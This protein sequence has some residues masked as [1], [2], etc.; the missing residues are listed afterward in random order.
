M[1]ILA[2]FKDIMSAN[3]NDLLDKCED[4]AKMVDQEMRK[5]REALADVKKET[6]AVMA[7][8]MAAKRR[9]DE[10]EED[11]QKF[12]NAAVKAVEA[13]NDDDARKLILR[14]QQ[15]EAKLSDAQRM[16]DA[17]HDSAVKMREMHDKLVSDIQ[18]LDDRRDS[19][20]AKV[21]QAKAQDRVNKLAGGMADSSASLSALNRMEAKAN[22]LL[23]EATAG[24]ELNK[25]P[26]DSMDNLVAKYGAKGGDKSVEDELASL[27][28][29]IG[30]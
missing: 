29:S 5:L 26:E 19:I 30:R 12:G 10:C 24:A 25:G 22:K 13:G 11:V 14:K 17:A 16:Y 23:D 20:K 15:C 6:Q 27:K 3:I 4:P 21:H 1:G 18:V 28:A 9:L 8:E 7:D 2:R